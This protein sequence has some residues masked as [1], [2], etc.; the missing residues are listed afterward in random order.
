MPTAY[1]LTIRE[2][3]VASALE[4]LRKLIDPTASPLA[5]VL[6]RRRFDQSDEAAAGLYLGIAVSQIEIGGP[7]TLDAEWESSDRPSLHSLWL[8]CSSTELERIAYNPTISD[9][10]L[11]IGLYDGPPSRTARRVL[12]ILRLYPWS[13][14]VPLPKQAT[15]EAVDLMSPT[16]KAPALELA[17]R[18]RDYLDRLAPDLSERPIATLTE[19]TR[20]DLAERVILQLVKDLEPYLVESRDSTARQLPA[21]QLVEQPTLWGTVEPLRP[22]WAKKGQKRA[23][24]Q[25]HALGGVIT[26]PEVASEMILAAL[27]EHDDGVIDFGDPAAGRGSFF[28]HLVAAVGDHRIASAIAVELDPHHA[29]LSEHLWQAHGLTVVTGDFLESLIEPNSRSLIVANPPYLR[30]QELDLAATKPW[31][32][33]IQ[34]DLNLTLSGRCDLSLYLILAAHK[35]ARQGAV[36]AWLI[37][38]EALQAN[39]ALP[40]REYLAN[41]VTLLRIHFFDTSESLFRNARVSS[42]FLLYRYQP[43]DA[44]SRVKITSGGTIAHPAAAVDIAQSHLRP[45]TKWRTL[46]DRETQ[47]PSAGQIELSQLFVT[48]RGIATG[49]NRVFVIDDEM[50]ESLRIPAEWTKPVIPRSRYLEDSIIRADRNGLPRTKQHV[51]LI[52]TSVD[53]DVILLRSPRLWEYLARARMQIGGRN[54]VSSRTPFYKQEQR[55]PAPFLFGYMSRQSGLVHSELPFFLNRS[56][57]TYLNNYIGLY[58]K[59]SML[60]AADQGIL[61]VHILELLRRIAPSELERRGR[62]YVSGLR[63]AEPMEVGRFRFPDNDQ[64]AKKLLR[65]VGPTI[66]TRKPRM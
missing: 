1:A 36:G 24:D 40:L 45:S 57:A 16:L 46:L 52:D 35:W 66:N 33:A 2:C 49:A 31:R 15:I 42:I 27:S 61:D 11:G 62:E 54:I 10:P 63:K 26:P 13:Y 34:K 60:E 48:R 56:I 23:T 58:P 37:S 32:Q 25:G 39:Y 47:P 19:S 12:D 59:F 65:I 22:S 43:P 8:A 53:S 18:S 21:R 6:V 50:R 28:A 3:P 7:F 44:A 17:T 29:S 9:T 4:V 20:V 55:P 41:R 38:G 64:L 30:S 14:R 51:W 5:Q